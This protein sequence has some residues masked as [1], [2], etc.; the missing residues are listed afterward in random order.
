MNKYYLDFT[1][2]GLPQMTNAKRRVAHWAQLQK[3]A[4]LWKRD[5][6]RYLADKKPPKPL[7][8]ASLI[9]T[10]G[11]SREP[12]YDGLV[13][14]FKHVIDGLVI[15]GI[16]VNDKREN[17]GIPTYIWEPAKPKGGYIRVRVE[18]IIPNDVL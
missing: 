2:P 15:A 12:D 18:E 16:L 17:I 6:F 5:L 14:G 3:E 11:S 9:L 7:E 10:R 13:S 4:N 1:L 8:N